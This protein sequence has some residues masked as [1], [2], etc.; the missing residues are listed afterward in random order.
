MTEAIAKDP[1][2]PLQWLSE[3]SG[4]Q[5]GAEIPEPLRPLAEAIWRAALRDA[6]RHA[7]ALHNIGQTAHELLKY[8]KCSPFDEDVRV[9]AYALE[10][11]TPTT[12]EEV[13]AF[14]DFLYDVHET[15]ANLKIHKS[16]PNRLVEPFMWMTVLMTATEWKNFF[17]LRCHPDAEIH[18]QKIA[19]MMRDALDASTPTKLQAGVW[20]LPFVSGNDLQKL[21]DDGYDEDAVKRISAARCARVSYL[22]HE[23]KRD[24]W[25]DLELFTRLE[26][27]SGFGH[28]SPPEH[29]AQALADNGPGRA[30]TRS[31]PFIGWKQFRKEFALENSEG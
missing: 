15:A 4:M 18:F 11:G 12:A 5:G 17:R 31:G 10:Q 9:R 7:K 27:G 2:I 24:P 3:Q 13:K 14:K 29:V 26:N 22:T 20:H 21:V 23:G 25:K 28:W 8:Y 19:G 1:V 30:L 16:I 6:Q